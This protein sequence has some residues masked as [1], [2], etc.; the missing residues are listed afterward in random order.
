MR[1]TGRDLKTTRCLIVTP[2][3]HGLII[4]KSHWHS[5]NVIFLTDYAFQIVTAVKAAQRQEKH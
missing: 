3:I 2:P 5:L 4:Y 1:P